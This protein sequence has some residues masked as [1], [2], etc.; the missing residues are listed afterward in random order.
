MFTET[1]LKEIGKE[2]WQNRETLLKFMRRH[3]AH[4]TKTDFK[5]F[6][7][8]CG[9]VGKTTLGKMLSG[10]FNFANLPSEYELSWKRENFVVANTEN[11]SIRI[12][13]GQVDKRAMYWDELTNEMAVSSKYYAVVHVVAW[14][15]HDLQHT[16]WRSH[17]LYEKAMKKEDFL[18]AYLFERRNLEL[19]TF[20]DLIP[21]LKSAPHKLELLTLAS[22][23]DLWWPERKKVQQHYSMGDYKDMINDIAL[24]RG[25]KLFNH[26]ITSLSLNLLNFRE[27]NSMTLA[28]T[29]AGYDRPLMLSNFVGALKKIRELTHE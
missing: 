5:F 3:F 19:T 9:G 8:G 1:I 16:S 25:P 11:A 29:A 27:Q 6:C 12:P 24:H 15:F 23:Q 2:V 18:E 20:R 14:G 10:E 7:F 4:L 13:P 22:K 28:E 26:R 17:P 21:H